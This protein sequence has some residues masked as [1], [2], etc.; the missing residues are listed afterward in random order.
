MLVADVAALSDLQSTGRRFARI[1]YQMSRDHRP[2]LENTMNLHQPPERTWRLTP[3]SSDP[4]FK[5]STRVLVRP[6][7]LDMLEVGGSTKCDYRSVYHRAPVARSPQGQNGL[8]PVL[9][10][11]PGLTKIKNPPL[12]GFFG[13]GGVG[14]DEGRCSTNATKGAFGPPQQSEGARRVQSP[15]AMAIEDNPPDPIKFLSRCFYSF[16]FFQDRACEDSVR[17]ILVP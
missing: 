3:T 17:A 16:L 1:E 2:I 12:G 9:G 6:I 13:F 5:A 8:R 4:I 7:G 15:E 10:N 11:P 14:L